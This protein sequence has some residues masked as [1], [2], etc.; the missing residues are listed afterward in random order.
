MKNGLRR[1]KYDRTILE[2][3]RDLM[4]AH[5]RDAKVYGYEA[6]IEALDLPDP[7]DMC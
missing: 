4:D 5:V 7:K 6:L 2:R 3:I 1:D